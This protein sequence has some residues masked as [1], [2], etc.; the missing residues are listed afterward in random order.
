MKALAA[1]GLGSNR[2]NRESWLLAAARALEHLPGITPKALSR[3]YSTTPIGPPQPSYLNAAMLL[4]TTLGPEEL[5]AAL[6]GV[7]AG[8]G[9]R[10]SEPQGPRT[11]DLDLLQFE[12]RLSDLPRVTLP[13]PRL[14]ERAFALVPLLE[15]WPEATDPRSGKPWRSFLERLGST[16]VSPGKPL[17]LRIERTDHEH[18][19]DHRFSVT[20]R[21]LEETLEK[22]ALAFIDFMVDRHLV[23]E[24]ERHLIEVHGESP[25]D[26]L[27]QL[28]S[29]ILFH[30]DGRL[31]VPKRAGL[32][33][34][35]GDTLQVA[36]YGEPLRSEEQVVEHVKAVTYHRAS[37]ER[38]R[39]NRLWKAMTVVDL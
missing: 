13:H 5:M 17:P 16:G 23:T 10:R 8:L 36:L 1:I 37:L 31:L 14:G 34:R 18:R 39:K 19:A 29:E 21:T 27:I 3:A 35:K 24:R 2:G 26:L 38:N 32:V 30:L 6:L 12:D 4:E 7:E 28:L 25:T 22:A 20:G 11:I 33:T 15:L 9:R